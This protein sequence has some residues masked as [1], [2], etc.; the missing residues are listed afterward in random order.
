[1][2][3]WASLR[4]ADLGMLLVAEGKAGPFPRS[5]WLKGVKG[6]HRKGV[7]GD[8]LAVR[9]PWLGPQVLIG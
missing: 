3:M 6:G 1:M 2:A 5:R 4:L 8:H 9:N 7:T